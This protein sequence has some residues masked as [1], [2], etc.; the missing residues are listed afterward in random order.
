MNTLR[1]YL[2]QLRRAL[3]ATQRFE[4]LRSHGVARPMAANLVFEEFY[5]SAARNEGNGRDRQPHDARDVTPILRASCCR[6]QHTPLSRGA[7]AG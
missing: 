5:A 2:A 3:A 7:A 6:R 1:M 4:L